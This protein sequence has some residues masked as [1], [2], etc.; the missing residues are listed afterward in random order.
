[1]HPKGAAATRMARANR[2]FIKSFSSCPRG[3]LIERAKGLSSSS[4]MRA[5]N[6]RVDRAQE[7]PGFAFAVSATTLAAI[8]AEATPD[9][10][11]AVLRHPQVQITPTSRPPASYRADE[12]RERRRHAA[13]GHWRSR[14]FR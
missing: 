10:T 3:V 13:I 9:S 2:R 12:V 14:V 1:M 7:A 4:G 8:P 11:S 6:E 5:A